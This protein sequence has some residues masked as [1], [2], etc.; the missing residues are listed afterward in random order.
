MSDKDQLQKT[1]AGDLKKALDAAN[2]RIEALEKAMPKVE[3]P[4][5]RLAKALG[6]N[7]TLAKAL[8]ERDQL[9]TKAAERIET[10]T[11]AFEKLSKEPVPPRAAL[12]AVSK[13]ADGAA[14]LG[15]EVEPVKKADG[16]VDEPL[17][18][19]KKALSQPVRVR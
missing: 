17:T 13:S 16:T 9:L 14:E 15:R 1:E 11:K 4:E 18:E 3:T 6:E 8:G 7:E 5:E 10:L 19:L 2:A 12:T